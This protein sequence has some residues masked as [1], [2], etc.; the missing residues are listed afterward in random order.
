MTDPAPVRVV[1]GGRLTAV[2]G[3]TGGLGRALTPLLMA[4]G[5]RVRALVRDP[6]AGRRLA[7]DGIEVV[8]GDLRDPGC[9]ARL[10]EGADVVHHLAAWMGSPAGQAAAVN[11]LGTRA[12]VEAAVAAG[13]R[14][15][16][17]ASSVA[18]YGPVTSGVIHEDAPLHKVGDAYS[19]SKVDGENAAFAAA[20]GSATEVVA[21]RPTMIYGPASGSW[22]LTPLNNLMRGLP[23]VIGDGSGRLDA[24][25]VGDVARAFALAA[26]AHGAAGRAFNVVGHSVSVAELMGAYGRMLGKTPRAV[27]RSL[28]ALGARAAAV[29]TSAL[30]GVDRLAP[31][32]VEVMMSAARFAGAAAEGVL[33]YVPEVTFERGMALTAAWLRAS[34]A[35]PGPRNALVVGAGRGLGRAVA[36]AL[37]AAYVKTYAADVDV[38]ALPTTTRGDLVPMQLDATS[39]RELADAVAAIEA[40]DG[41]LDASVTTVGQLRPG[42]LEVQP[43]EQVARQLELNAMVPLKVARAV[44]PGMRRRRRGRIVNVSSTNG[45]QVTPLMGAYSAGKF[46]LEALS[47][48]LR[49][50][51]KPFGVDVVLVQPAAMA[52][53]FAEDAKA[54]LRSEAETFPEPWSGVMMN[55]HDSDLWGE[56]GAVSPAAVA[57]VVVRQVLASR[58]KS[59][60]VGSLAVPAVRLFALLPDGLKDAYFARSLRLGRSQR[61]S[62]QSPRERDNSTQA[63][64]GPSR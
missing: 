15:V 10:A 45:F 16:L 48:A 38:R 34:G 60:V 35:L 19:D 4:A 6:E 12:L 55:L 32:M 25:Y 36:E 52:T 61:P 29:V 46:A 37:A 31:E 47:D 2:T 27:P 49:Q 41:W 59:R 5:D 39:E 22:T 7:G 53:P 17:L 43:L 51:L 26:D 24:V 44:A 21:L 63:H 56:R 33:G 40:E 8:V 23:V 64:S 9:L 28:A 20:G 62:R 1:A 18:V 14:R 50:E 13:V 54:A 3:A 58:P 11:V 57:A 30:P 42:A